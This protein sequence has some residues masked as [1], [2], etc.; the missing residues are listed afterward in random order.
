LELEKSSS[1]AVTGKPLPP[2]VQLPKSTAYTGSSSNDSS[3]ATALE[4]AKEKVKQMI[5]RNQESASTDYE[6]LY[7]TFKKSRVVPKSS[8]LLEDNTGADDGGKKK[9]DLPVATSDTG[10]H[11]VGKTTE[12]LVAVA[13]GEKN[14]ESSKPKK[15]LPFI[16]KLP[17]LKA[18]RTAKQAASEQNAADDKSKIEIKP[19]SVSN[20][21]STP[22]QSEPTLSSPDAVSSE[23]QTEQKWSVNVPRS[24]ARNGGMGQRN[25]LDAFLTIGDPESAQSQ[26]VPVLNVGP[27]TRSE[28]MLENQPTGKQTSSKTAEATDTLPP[29]SKDEVQCATQTGS[30]ILSVSGPSTDSKAA[31]TDDHQ[32]YDT[33]VTTDLLP[34]KEP[35]SATVSGTVAA[36]DASPSHAEED[37]TSAMS[38]EIDD[39][40]EDYEA[41][42]VDQVPKLVRD[43]ETAQLL[44]QISAT[45]M[46]PAASGCSALAFY[47]V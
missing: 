25:S 12:G 36:T 30:D 33:A 44:P 21:A 34:E 28:F 41:D 27:Q 45:W 10:S 39:N 6:P 20:V 22:I 7:P 24:N 23:E 4:K 17:F 19:V 47:I 40:T 31:N 8:G 3:L 38:L 18:A 32:L 16:G 2:S 1:S 46:Q 9:S 29:A 42:L 37:N 5:K 43:E 26:V 35:Q 11:H 15:S 13:D 14:D